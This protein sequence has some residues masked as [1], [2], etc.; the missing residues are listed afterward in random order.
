M[1]NDMGERMEHYE[2]II[3]AIGGALETI[4]GAAADLE[5]LQTKLRR[6]VSAQEAS[7]KETKEFFERAERWWNERLDARARGKRTGIKH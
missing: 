3:T 7:I 4:R 5:V 2:E 1:R 6:A